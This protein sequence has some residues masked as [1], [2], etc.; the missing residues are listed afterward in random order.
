MT[1]KKKKEENL[2]SINNGWACL[3]DKNNMVEKK[4]LKLKTETTK[5]IW[6]DYFGNNKKCTQK[7]ILLGKGGGNQEEK[8]IKTETLLGRCF[9]CLF[10]WK[11][12]FDI[13]SSLRRED[14][15]HKQDIE[16]GMDHYDFAWR[17]G[18]RLRWMGVDFGE[19]LGHWVWIAVASPETGSG[20][21]WLA[22][23]PGMDQR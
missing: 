3:M 22:W 23:S 19:M 6:K 1:L 21:Q 13:H 8:S 17:P 16:V 7:I 14:V 10:L 5:N 20:L 15:E 12:E 18:S 2:S 11:H 9:C 4:K